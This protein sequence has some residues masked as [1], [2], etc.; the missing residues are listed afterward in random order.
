[1]EVN[2]GGWGQHFNESYFGAPQGAG[3]GPLNSNYTIG[4]RFPRCEISLLPA[5]G[6]QWVSRRSGRLENIFKK[7]TR[8]NYSRNVTKYFKNVTF[9]KKSTQKTQLFM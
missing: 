4:K 3:I 9:P 8:K 6:W 7:G 2:C 5:L 1:M